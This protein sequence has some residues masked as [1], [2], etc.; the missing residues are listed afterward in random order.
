MQQHKWFS[1]I[2]WNLVLEKKI[3]APIVPVCHGPGDARNFEQY[4][5]E[6]SSKNDHIDTHAF[7]HYF[8]GF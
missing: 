2:D 1:G 5:E 7:N 6:I 4:Q 8:R 3:Q